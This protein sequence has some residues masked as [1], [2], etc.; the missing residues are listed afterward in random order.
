MFPLVLLGYI[1]V[2]LQHDAGGFDSSVH[3]SEEVRNANI[4]IPWAIL[5]A[6]GLGSVLGWG[7]TSPNLDLTVL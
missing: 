7:I 6:A 4:A 2:I 3:I 1:T 5:C